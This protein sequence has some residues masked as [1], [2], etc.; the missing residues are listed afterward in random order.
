MRNGYCAMKNTA[1]CRINA[2]DLRQYCYCPRILYFTYVVPV[3]HKAT[4]KMNQGLE[5]H[6]VLEVLERRRTL[7]R[8][9]LTGGKKL[10]GLYLTSEKLGITGRPDMVILAKNLA[11]PVEF[12]FGS[13]TLRQG[14]ILQLGAYGL[15]VEEHFGITVSQGIIFLVESEGVR[16]VDIDQK[17]REK[18][19]SAIRDIGEMI[20]EEKMPSGPTGV[21]KC[22]DCEYLNWC[23]DRK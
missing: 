6:T 4:F 23:G 10:F 19:L 3:P 11:L 20:V 14:H 16:R 15:L 1:P 8:Y 2:L 13:G 9:K 22:L 7:Q 5:K 17:L 12:K 21:G 18:V